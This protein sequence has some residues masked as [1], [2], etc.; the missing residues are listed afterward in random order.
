MRSLQLFE[1]VIQTAANQGPMQEQEKR[2]KK[3]EEQ[4]RKP[5]RWEK[6]QCGLQLKRIKDLI[7]LCETVE[8]HGR[9]LGVRNP[10]QQPI[11]FFGKRSQDSEPSF[12]LS[13]T[14][15]LSPLFVAVI[16]LKVFKC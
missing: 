7:A 11:T 1:N 5:V 14:L 15:S 10:W 9:R 2:A 16:T 12:D 4:E 13:L 8:L 6:E 3:E